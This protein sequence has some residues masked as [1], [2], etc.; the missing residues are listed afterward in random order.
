MAGRGDRLREGAH[1]GSPLD[2]PARP[3]FLPCPTMPSLF[4]TGYLSAW[5][6]WWVGSGDAR[7]RASP[8]RVSDRAEL[9]VGRAVRAGSTVFSAQVD[10]QDAGAALSDRHERCCRSRYQLA[11]SLNIAFS[12]FKF[13][14]C[15]LTR[16][17]DR[18]PPRQKR[19]GFLCGTDR[20]VSRKVLA[21]WKRGD[22]RPSHCAFTVLQHCVQLTSTLRLLGSATGTD[23]IYFVLTRP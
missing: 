4:L 18:H 23:P 1:A 22:Q 2:V 6:Q 19:M 20:S 7:G 11:C 14:R 8:H 17:V 13:L 9:A 21:W 15:T 5:P 12:I 16:L 10:Q 3:R